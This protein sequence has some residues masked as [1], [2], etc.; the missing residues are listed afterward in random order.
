MNDDDAMCWLPIRLSSVNNYLLIKKELMEI[1]FL[2]FLFCFFSVR[3]P[4]RS[5]PLRSADGRR[6]RNAKRIAAARFANA[7]E[8]AYK[9]FRVLV[10]PVSCV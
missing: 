7:S 3:L 4:A 9:I 1:L 10:W 5:S 6:K 8:R 2:L